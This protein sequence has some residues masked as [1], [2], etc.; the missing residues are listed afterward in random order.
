MVERGYSDH[1]EWFCRIGFE[2]DDRGHN[3]PKACCV[4]VGLRKKEFIERELHCGMAES[5]ESDASTLKRE[6]LE[7]FDLVFVRE[8]IGGVY[9]AP[10]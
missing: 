8:L 4:S 10:R 9:L 5:N 6:V 7:G 3:C 1:I 2:T